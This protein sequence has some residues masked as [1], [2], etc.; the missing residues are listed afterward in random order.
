MALEAANTELEESQRTDEA[1]DAQLS[2][3]RKEVADQIKKNIAK[4][5]EFKVRLVSDILGRLHVSLPG[6][7]HLTRI[8]IYRPNKPRSTRA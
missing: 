2:A 4:L 5:Q 6:A 7:H 3:E 1:A 8:R